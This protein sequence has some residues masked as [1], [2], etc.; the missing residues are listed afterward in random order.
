MST[1]RCMECD[2]EHD[3]AVRWAF[4]ETSA[5]AHLLVDDV[6]SAIEDMGYR[7]GDLCAGCAKRLYETAQENGGGR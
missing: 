5:F 7:A 3:A 1:S 6:E 2:R 4:L